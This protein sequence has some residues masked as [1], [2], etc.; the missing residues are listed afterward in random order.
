MITTFGYLTMFGC[1][2]VL[3]APLIFVF[4][5]VETRSD[6][7][8]LE[9]TCKRPI[10]SKTHDIGSWSVCLSIF[11]FLSVFSNIIVSCYCSDQIDHLFPWLI[12]YKNSDTTAVATVFAL[13]H[14][15]L[16]TVFGLTLTLDRDPA[17]IG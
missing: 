2:F 6:L 15:L 3:S 14:V 7:F 17:W 4:I 11:C 10:P 8:K 5:L 1:C 16:F 9:Q 12:E 13:E